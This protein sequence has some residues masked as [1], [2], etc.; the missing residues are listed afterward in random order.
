MALAHAF[1]AQGQQ[2]AEEALK[3][4]EAFEHVRQQIQQAYH[5]WETLAAAIE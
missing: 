3:L 1:S 5:Q 2:S 4:N